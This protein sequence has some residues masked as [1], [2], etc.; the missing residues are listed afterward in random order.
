MTMTTAQTTPPPTEFPAAAIMAA[1][2]PENTESSFLKSVSEHCSRFKGADRKRSI[3]Q[4]AVTGTLYM[5]YALLAIYAVNAGMIWLTML[6]WLPAGGLLV[7]LFIIQHDCGHGSYFSKRAENDFVGRL[8]SVFTVTPYGLWRDAHNQ[9]HAAS[10]HLERRG[11]GAIDTITVNE[12]KN[13]SPK[14]QF[15]YRLYRNPFVVLVI[16]PLL[17]VIFIQRLPMKAPGTFFE[18]YKGIPVKKLWRSVMYT[19]FAMLAFY[20]SIGALFGFGAMFLAFLPPIM[21]A[22]WAGG[23]L[24][25]IQH[26]FEDAYWEHNENWEFQAAALHGSSYYKLPKIMQWF[27]GNIG[28]HHIHHLCSLIPNYKLQE[29]MDSHRDLG[30]INVMTFRDSLRSIPL[31][32]WDEDAKKMVTFR[33]AASA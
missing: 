1:Q 2:K 24:F 17:H 26:Q 12:Y 30:Q 28:L 15:Q 25:F 27:T 8:L 18:I 6:L 33:Q 23:W 29:C 9:H 5:A 3:S 11:L 19:N 4:F 7:R 16:G 31:A 22:A 20:G 32:L 13:L 21:I 10:G 14:K